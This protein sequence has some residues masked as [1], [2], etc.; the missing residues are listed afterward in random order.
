M[1]KIGHQISILLK[2]G[3][4]KHK[5]N[6]NYILNPLCPLHHK[7]FILFLIYK[8]QIMLFFLHLLYVCVKGWLRVVY[9][10]QP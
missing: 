6:D 5:S 3:K 8:L 2:P 7:I 9:Q 4:Q 1:L 10:T